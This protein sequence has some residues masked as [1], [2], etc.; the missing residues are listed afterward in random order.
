MANIESSKEGKG[1]GSEG[2]GKGAELAY[3]DYKIN[4]KPKYPMIARRNGY[5][6]V[7]LLKVWVLESGKVGRIELEESSGYGVLDKAA[8]KAVENWIFIPGKRNGMSISS[9]VTI[10]IRFEL[11]SG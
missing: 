1:I 2:S 7:V 4:P 8:L 10:P 3:P 9:W 6:G 11:R 5:E